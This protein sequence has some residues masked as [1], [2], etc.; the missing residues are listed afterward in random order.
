MKKVAPP[1]I[2]PDSNNKITNL[3]I[4]ATHD[5]NIDE[6]AMDEDSDEEGI[7]AKQKSAAQAQKDLLLQSTHIKKDLPLPPNPENVIIRRDYDPK[8]MKASKSS[9]APGA[10]D[11]SYFKSPLTGE[12][13]PAAMMSEHMRIS[14]LDP[15]WL[16]QKQREKRERE[17]QEEVLAGGFNIEETLKRLAEYRSDVFGSGADEALIG[18]KV[19]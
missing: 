7:A 18:K 8:A 13:V 12:L 11:S 16:E 10:R 6:V 15:K 19:C 1:V 17:D 5:R 14:M 9:L 4:P 2:T 3:V